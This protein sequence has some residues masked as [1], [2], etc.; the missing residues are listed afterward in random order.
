MQAQPTITESPP[1]VKIVKAESWHVSMMKRHL[2][3]ED[4]REMMGW[5]ISANKG[6]WCSYKESLIRRT[7]MIDGEPAAMWGVRSTL[8]GNVGDIWLQTTPAVRWVS[9]LKFARVYQD[10]VYKMLNVFKRLENWVDNDYDGA[11]RLLDISG[12]SLG[13]PEPVGVNGHL[14]RKFWIERAKGWPHRS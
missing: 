5:G 10:Q 13:E 9:P 11:V 2:R 1:L 6:L 7:A 3:M 12:F 14:Y 8:L 4:E